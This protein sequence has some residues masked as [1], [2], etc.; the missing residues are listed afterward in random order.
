MIIHI[1]SL[2]EVLNENIETKK[3]GV[4]TN[5][6]IAFN[7]KYIHNKMR[8]IYQFKNIEILS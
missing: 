1:P 6:G 7:L 5:H 8:L 3:T 4:T 2:Y